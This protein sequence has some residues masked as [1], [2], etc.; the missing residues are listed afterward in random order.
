[1]IYCEFK[2]IKSGLER[3]TLRDGTTIDLE[4]AGAFTFRW[5]LT[6]PDGRTKC[7]NTHS[8]STAKTS[9]YTHYRGWIYHKWQEGIVTASGYLVPLGNEEE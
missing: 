9:W 7:G 3:A 6:F 1:M 2:R 4:K 5:R 8:Y